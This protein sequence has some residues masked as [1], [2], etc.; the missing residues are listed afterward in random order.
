MKTSVQMGLAVAAISIVS[1]SCLAQPG[2][3][4][5]ADQFTDFHPG[6][7]RAQVQQ[8]YLDAKAQGLLPRGDADRWTTDASGMDIGARGPAGSRYQGLT[9]EEVINEL[10]EYKRTY[11]PQDTSSIYFGE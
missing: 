9:R 4:D 8:E 11:N 7:T 3:R 6:K 1:G 10:R 5:G 2:I